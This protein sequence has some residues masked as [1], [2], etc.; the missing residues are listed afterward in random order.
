MSCEL[1][2]PAALSIQSKLFP[3]VFL[4]YN[5]M[6]KMAQIFNFGLTKITELAN[7]K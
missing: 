4:H 1:P 7:S 3:S 2:V 5:V 6:H